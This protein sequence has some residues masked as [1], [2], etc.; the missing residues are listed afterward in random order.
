MPAKASHRIRSGPDVPGSGSSSMWT[1]R[2]SNPHLTLCKSV[3]LPVKLSAL[4][5]LTLRKV[6]RFWLAKHPITGCLWAGLR[7]YF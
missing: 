5:S 1:K 2:E 6:G 4:G 3:A 7:P